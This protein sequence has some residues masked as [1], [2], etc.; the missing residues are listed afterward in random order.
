M[1]AMRHD[2]LATWRDRFRSEK[3]GPR[4]SGWLHFGFTTCGSLAVIVFAASR[5]HDVRPCEWALVPIFFLIANFGEYLGH[6]G[7]MHHRR[8][9]LGLV[10]ERHT[11][12]HHRFFTVEAM[13]CASSRDYKIILFPPVM[14][15]FFVGMLATPIGVAFYFAAS[16]NAGYLFAVVAVGYFLLYEWLHFAYH[17]REGSLVGR[18]P[19]IAALRRHHQAHHD[20]A[21]MAQWNF[22]ITFPLGDLLFG[23][24]YRGPR[25]KP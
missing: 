18:L 24:G 14:L 16:P 19:I 20:P 2:E 25:L 4:Y 22:N 10:F 13:T 23:T 11:L 15:V 1:F 9:G 12:Q 7:P 21:L 8:N 3:I 6:R 17:Q 5:L